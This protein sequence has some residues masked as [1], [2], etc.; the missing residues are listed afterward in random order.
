MTD[1]DARCVYEC[2]ERVK[3]GVLF[4]KMNREMLREKSRWRR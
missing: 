2:A 3:A 4:P 1:V